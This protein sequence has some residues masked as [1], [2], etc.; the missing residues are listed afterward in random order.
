MPGKTVGKIP[1]KDNHYMFL[2]IE[3]FSAFTR[4]E[5]RHVILFYLC[6]LSSNYCCELVTYPC[7]ALMFLSNFGVFSLFLH[8]H[9]SNQLL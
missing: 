6:F 4:A 3:G 8:F 1:P 7:F 2:L 5:L 9:Y